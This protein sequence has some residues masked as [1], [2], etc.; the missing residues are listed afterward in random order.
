M[1][2]IIRT[3][4]TK[5]GGKSFLIM[6]AAGIIFVFLGVL[7]NMADWGGVG[8]TLPGMILWCIAECQLLRAL[9]Q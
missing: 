9:M 2:D 3:L 5:P 6:N 8:L 1:K 4:S 7:A